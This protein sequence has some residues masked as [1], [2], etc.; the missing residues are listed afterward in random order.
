MLNIDY[1]ML[2]VG[3]EYRIGVTV[4]PI[5][6]LANIFLG[7]YYNLSVWYKLTD[8]TIFGAYIAIAGAGVTIVFNLLLIPRMGYVGS[9]WATL[10][11]YVFMA[12]ASYLIGKRK[13]YVPYPIFKITGYFVLTLGIYL[14]TT[15]FG[16]EGNMKWIINNG[17]L[18]LLATFIYILEKPKK[19]II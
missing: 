14:I 15:T 8:K 18:L 19:I 13:Y 16:F 11:C 12:T 17:I 10:F 6:L 3:E 2:F 5:L 9:A 1:V 7:I 4:V